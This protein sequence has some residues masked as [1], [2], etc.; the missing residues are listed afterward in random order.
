MPLLS[1]N[2]RERERELVP[3]QFKRRVQFSG[4]RMHLSATFGAL[5]VQ[6]AVGKALCR[7]KGMNHPWR[8]E[9]A[10]NTVLGLEAEHGPKRKVR[11]P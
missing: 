1:Y 2:Q 9:G 3:P 4:V 8:C 7:A 5:F 6:E 11:N 10:D